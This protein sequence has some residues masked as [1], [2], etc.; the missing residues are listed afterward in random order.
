[1]LLRFRV[2]NH[3]SIRDEAELSLISSSLR[4][5]TPPDG[6]WIG[7][8]TRVAAIYGANAAGK[9]NLL[10]AF[11]F[12]ISAVRHSA[13]TWAEKEDFPYQ[14]FRLTMIE[15]AHPSFYEFSLTVDDVRYDYGFRCT[16]QGV[17]S[18]W[19]YSYPEGRRRRLFVRESTGGTP[20]S[21]SNHLPGDKALAASLLRPRSLFLSVAANSNHNFLGRIQHQITRNIQYA[22]YTEFDRRTRLRMV[23]DVIED[24]DSLQKTIALLRMA[25]LGIRGVTVR[26]RER[27]TFLAAFLE[28]ASDDGDERDKGVTARTLAATRKNLSFVH[29]TADGTEFE[30]PEIDQ[31]SG[32]LAWISLA[33][34][35]LHAF[36]DGSV[37]LVDELDASLHPYLAATLVGMFKAPEINKTGAQIVFTTHDVSFMSPSFPAALEPDEIWFA[38]KNSDGATELYSLAEYPTRRSDNFAKRYLEGRYGAVP[39]VD[40]D[41]LA[42]VLSRVET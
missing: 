42:G 4:T 12:A 6:D 35:A 1:M 24:K 38:E 21:F 33:V 28:L 15:E 40:P 29:T 39:L 3:R 37:L 16:D 2:A 9:S 20:I 23:R 30:I 41:A 13:T 36:Q 18:E 32:T 34:P 14:P 31:S 11:D 5:I 25:D 26:E 22:R 7:A 27:P 19:L 17:H 8:T 10:D